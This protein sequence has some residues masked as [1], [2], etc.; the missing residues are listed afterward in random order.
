MN[1]K[2]INI[3][4]KAKRGQFASNI[5]FAISMLALSSLIFL[6]AARIEHRY[7]TLLITLS[8][9]L[10]FASTGTSRWVTVSRTDLL[11][12]IQRQINND[13]EALKLLAERKTK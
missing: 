2:D 6:E 1:E 13:V 4:L 7:T 3:F 8:M 10:I 5:F 11:S 9:M 12:I